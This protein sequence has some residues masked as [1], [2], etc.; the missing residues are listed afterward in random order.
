MTRLFAG[1]PF[2]IP[3]ECDRCGKPESDCTCTVAEK[4]AADAQREIESARI[5]PEKQIARTQIEKRKGGRTVTV[6]EGLTARAN[7]LPALLSQLQTACGSGGTVKAKD[8]RIELQGNHVET[9]RNC[10]AQLGFQVR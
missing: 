7:D 3:P 9:A 5:A 2:D 1:T 6:I 8:D 4:A 10:L